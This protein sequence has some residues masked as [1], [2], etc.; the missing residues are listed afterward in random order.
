MS[1]VVYRTLRG[2][3]DRR[4]LVGRGAVGAVLRTEQYNERAHIVAPVVAL[5]GDT[6]IWPVNAPEPE[7]VP[8]EL[9]AQT[10]QGWNGRPVTA[11]HPQDETGATS[12]NEPR[13]LESRA[14][15]QVFRSA[16]ADN[17]LRLEAWMDPEKAERVGA[18]AISVVSRISAQQLVEVSVG[19][20]I[21]LVERP[22][23]D[24]F[25][26][27]YRFAWDSLVQ[28]HL[29]MLREDETGACSNAMGCGSPRTAGAAHVHRV[30]LFTGSS[31]LLIEERNMTIA[32]ATPP[33]P[34][35]PGTHTRPPP[36]T[37][38]A[39]GGTPPTPPPHQPGTGAPPAAPPAAPGTQTPP[40]STP[41]AHPTAPTTTSASERRSLRERFLALLPFIHPTPA[42]RAAVTDQDLRRMLDDA[43]RAVEP[44]YMGIDV[45]DPDESFVVYSAM[46]EDRWLLL[47]RTFSV[48]GDGASV[49]IATDRVEVQPVTKFEPVVAA[50]RAAG[51][52]C[53]GSG[54]EGE[55]MLTAEQRAARAT[56]VQALIANPRSPFAASDEA[57]LTGLTEARLAEFERHA[58]ETPT[59]DPNATPPAT[60][61]TGG[62]PGE[63]PG[64]HPP[65]APFPDQPAGTQ[66][67][68]APRVPGTGTQP[69][70][71]PGGGE[72]G[73]Q[74]GQG[75]GGNQPG[76]QG[77]PS[78][79]AA[80][81]L[82]PKQWMA[83]AP[84]EVRSLV[85][86]S[87]AAD[88]ARKVTLVGQL[89]TAQSVYTEAQLATF[90]VPRLEEIAALVGARVPEPDFTGVGLPRAAATGAQ[91]APPPIDM[92]SRIANA[93][94]TNPQRQPS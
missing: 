5:V 86:R 8:A 76:N 13:V 69:R 30:H 23:V 36:A 84:P 17:L 15:G 44:G 3:L 81:Q 92:A 2:M 83:Q 20:F 79:A 90:E 31:G 35:S 78:N 26:R 19:C 52:G 82:T 40:A 14:F 71:T 37:S 68:G 6:V 60:P 58:A 56:R 46:P 1:A 61:G 10:P 80:A 77:Q 45:V 64:V 22:G 7:F 62:R 16:F 50:A 33:T 66:A 63:Q 94:N 12:A 65:G 85:E 27:S 25:G 21:T 74:G 51:C 67:P 54:R 42:P 9:L 49:E 57:Y 24:R 38:P 18:D 41:P 55:T 29:A 11:S 53:G 93:R 73:A 48:A 87:R 59:S 70:S 4:V 39:P 32:A 89:K 28:D 43:L 91:G 47:Q 34:G 88:A 75:E 72:E